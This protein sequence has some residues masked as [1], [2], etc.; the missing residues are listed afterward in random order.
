MVSCS[1]LYLY[2]LLPGMIWRWLT[3]YKEL[4]SPSSYVYN[5]YPDGMQWLERWQA[6]NESSATMLRSIDED[7]FKIEE[8]VSEVNSSTPFFLHMDTSK[9]IFSPE[10][11]SSI[12]EKIAR[13][14]GLAAPNTSIWYTTVHGSRTEN[15]KHNSICEFNNVTCHEMESMRAG[16]ETVTMTRVWQF[17]KAK[18]ESRVGFI[19]VVPGYNTTLLTEETGVV[20]KNC[21]DTGP[22]CQLCTPRTFDDTPSAEKSLVWLAD[23]SYVNTLP[24]PNEFVARMCGRD[25]KKCQSHAQ[26]WIY[27]GKPECE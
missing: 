9:P 25:Y 11:S 12:M 4:P 3:W 20:A 21:Q 1:P 8:V 23:C 22:A 17:C 26:S 5:F 7:P 19:H 15:T 18:P 24:S 6:V 16:M 27:S 2:F 10:N 14:T 13:V